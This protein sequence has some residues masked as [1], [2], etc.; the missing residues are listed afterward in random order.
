MFAAA[1]FSLSDV[2]GYNSDRVIFIDDIPNEV[3]KYH[4]FTFGTNIG[5]KNPDTPGGWMYN[6]SVLYCQFQSYDS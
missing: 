1:V 5:I 3:I 4:N 6:R 2:S